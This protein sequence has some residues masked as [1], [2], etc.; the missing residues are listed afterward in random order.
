MTPDKQTAMEIIAWIFIAG[1]IA[2]YLMWLYDDKIARPRRERIEREWASMRRLFE[3]NLDNASRRA[4]GDDMPYLAAH[5]TD[6]DLWE[7]MQKA[8]KS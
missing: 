2:S 1:L 5:D 7:Q 8:A 6:E 4:I 3:P